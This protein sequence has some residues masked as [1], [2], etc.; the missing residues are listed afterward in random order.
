[1]VYVTRPAA[2]PPAR[3]RSSSTRRQFLGRISSLTA[4][5]A[6]ASV[7]NLP[8]LPPFG[9]NTAHAAAVDP[10]NDQRFFDE[11]YVIRNPVEASADSTSLVP[12]TEPELT[13]GGELNKLALNIALGRDVAGVHWRSDG[14]EGLKLGEAAAISI[15]TDASG[16]FNERFDGFMLTKFG[17]T[18]VTV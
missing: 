4:A 14:I 5:A 2:S 8:A 11:A 17:D 13:V 18:I 9:I 15:L 1:M 12:Y 3:A 7:V 6:T 10:T 16:C